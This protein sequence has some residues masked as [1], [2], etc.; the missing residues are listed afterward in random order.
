VT[1]RQAVGGL[2]LVC[3]IW[4]VTFTITK[5]ALDHVSPLLFLGARFTLATAVIALSLLGATPAELRGGL[6]LGLLF[7]TGFAFQTFGLQYTTPSRSAFITILSTPLV[8][9]VHFVVSRTLPRLPTLAAICLAVAGTYLLTSPAGAAGLNRGDA[10][11]LGCAVVFAGQIVAAGHFAPRIPILRLLAIELGTTAILSLATSPV[12]ETPRFE[13][14]A[15]LLLIVLFL[16]LTGL[17]S[18]DMQLR[19]QRVLSP[20]HTALVFTLEPVF[21]SVT[22]YLVLGERLTAVQLAG[23]ALILTAI[24]TP[25]FERQAA[26]A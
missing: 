18:F 21:A 2:V 4:G 3:L 19:A 5:Q 11:T 8:P 24:A 9:L 25:A 15:A 13:P 12:L 14:S 23:A 7:W 16:A 20:T 26:T 17:W 22:S 10:L 1:R 6:I